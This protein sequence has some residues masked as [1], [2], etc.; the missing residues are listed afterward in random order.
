VP[1]S[2]CIRTDLQLC[3]ATVQVTVGGSTR[4]EP[5]GYGASGGA[6][7][8]H[9]SGFGR[10]DTQW[11]ATVAVATQARSAGPPR[12]GSLA[13]GVARLPLCLEPQGE[14]RE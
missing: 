9:D 2:V 10:L 1:L 5:V 8:V 7:G 12:V 11:G 13:H 4:N 14:Y 6:P 3:D